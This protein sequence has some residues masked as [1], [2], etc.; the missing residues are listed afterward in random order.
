M[1]GISRHRFQRLPIAGDPG[2][3]LQI[4][5]MDETGGRCED[6][7][8]ALFQ[9]SM[10]LVPI[11]GD[12]SGGVPVP[13]DRLQDVT[14]VRRMAF[15]GDH[16]ICRL[17]DQGRGLAGGVQRIHCD[18][19]SCDVTPL[20]QVLGGRD[21]ATLIV[22]VEHRKR[23]TGRMIGERDRLIMSLPVARG[24]RGR[25]QRCTNPQAPRG[26]WTGARGGSWTWRPGRCD[27]SLGGTT[28]PRP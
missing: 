23:R 27:P 5:I 14:C 26:R 1:I 24:R 18:D 4:R 25:V 9:A 19:M 12:V 20:Q 28:P 6:I 21:L 16:I 11:L 10:I 8:G 7:N 2:D 22:D 13:V 3:L 15:H 17:G